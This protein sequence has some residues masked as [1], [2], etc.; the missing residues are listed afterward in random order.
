MCSLSLKQPFLKNDRY[1]TSK[2]I[3]GMLTDF[4]DYKKIIYNPF[5]LD[6]KAKIYLN[7]LGYDHVIH[8]DEDFFENYDKY[9]YDI[10]IT[11]PP[12]TIKKRIFK[13]LYEINKPFIVIVPIATITKLFIKEIFKSDVEITDIEKLQMIIPNKRM[14]FEKNGNQLKRCYFDCVFLC[15]KMN[16]K[17]SIVY[18]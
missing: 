7:E 17:S 15:Y 18:L 13:K 5:Y 8:N 14:Q 6:G 4:V 10:I 16:L 3:Y 9:E 11:N 2:Y 1:G 12:Y